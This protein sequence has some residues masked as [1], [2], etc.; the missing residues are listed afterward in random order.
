MP[1]SPTLSS[2]G[3]SG[4]VRFKRSRSRS[5]VLRPFGVLS[6]FFGRSTSLVYGLFTK[7]VSC[8]NL[9]SA[10]FVSGWLSVVVVVWSLRA[11]LSLIGLEA[12]GLVD[13]LVGLGGSCF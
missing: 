13:G 1:P 9:R 5:F 11:F 2:L 7:L 4:F 3:G 12:L 8:K 10:V 6:G